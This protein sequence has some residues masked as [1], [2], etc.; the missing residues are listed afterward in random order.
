MGKVKKKY[1]I[2]RDRIL[3][4][5]LE[6]GEL[7]HT[8]IKEH[9]GIS[10]PV[11]ASILKILKEEKLVIDVVDK[12]NIQAGRPP[13]IV[14]IKGD[15]G[16]ILGIDI[17][18]INTNYVLLDLGQ[19]IVLE[20][21]RKSIS[22]SNDYAAIEKLHLEVTEI[23]KKA[24]VDISKVMG[25][26]VAIPGLVQGPKGRSDTY[27]NFGS[28]KLKDV[29]S[30][31][32]KVPVHIEH[33]VKA[34]ALGELKFGLAKG[35]QNVLCINIGWGIAMGIII[36]GQ[37]YYGSDDYAGEFGHMQINQEGDLCYCGKRGCL[38]TMA[39]GQAIA[40]NAKEKIA[41]GAVTKI[42]LDEDFNI[43]SLDAKVII[44]AAASGDQFSIEILEEAGRNI[45]FGVAQVINILN[46]EMIIFG[47]RISTAEK[48]IIDTISTTSMKFSL[49]HLNRNT[50]F[51]VSQLGYKA[52][53]LGVAFLASNE[54]F[55]V[56]YLNPSAFV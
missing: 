16:Y 52:G 35:H 11:V 2:R 20:E 6:H 45:G 54:L 27:F 30:N 51:V 21:R 8:D 1:Q 49:T 36:N 22:L 29:L 40:H 48:F 26:G 3:K 47:G 28:T 14:K 4:A 33:D 5:L 42:T 24:D 13:A 19:N 9:T 10:L 44:E 46:P 43:E 56:D 32:F 41:K 25:I 39:S 38:E 34:M 31:E 55:E 50:R 12:N 23:L 15:A 53:A 37:L 17:G 7:S 18:R